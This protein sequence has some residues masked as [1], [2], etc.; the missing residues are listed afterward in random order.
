M[1]KLDELIEE[2]CPDGVEYVKLKEVAIVSGAGVDKKIKADEQPV[3]LLNYMDVYRDNY[4]DNSLDFMEVTASESKISQ[5]NVLKGDIFITPSSEVLNDIGN[6]AVIIEDLENVVYSYHVMRIRL[7]E[8]NF[9]TSKYIGY[10]FESRYV[11]NQINRY[12]EGITRYGLTKTKWENI[13]ILLPHL[14]IQEEIVRILDSFTELTAGLQEELDKELAARKKQYEYYRDELLTFRDEVGHKTLKEMALDFGR[15]RSTHR[16]RNDPRLYGG[17]IP[18]IQ[19]G[20]VR[21]AS[22]II[23]EYSQTYSEFGLK[24]SKLWPK[25]TLCITIAA[26]IAETSILGFDACFPDSII[27]FVANPGITSSS[28]IEYILSSIKS[29]LESMGRGSAQRNINLGTFM[30]L[31]IPI[32]PLAEQERVV[33]ILDK[34]DAL[35][36]D[37]SVGLPAEIEARQK[38]YEYYREKLLTFKEQEARE[39]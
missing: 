38:Q 25:G 13:A 30:N 28:Y 34:F 22:H 23:K 24:Q 2:L 39:A 1:S 32:P 14:L 4:I 12:A 27:G 26:N 5:C 8:Q 10:I 29:K 18:F 17:D 31:K 6:A 11:Q 37:I 19:T 15:G 36:D 9:I 33:S 3:K 21:S 35:I 7:K 20:D 16:P